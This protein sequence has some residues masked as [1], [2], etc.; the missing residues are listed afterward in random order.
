MVDAVEGIALDQA[1]LEAIYDEHSAIR[2]VGRPLGPGEIGC[3][4]SHRSVY[5]MIVERGIAL[6][7]VLEE[8]AILGPQFK[9]LWQ[10]ASALPADVDLLLLYSEHGFVRRQPSATL[11]GCGLHQAT[12]MLSHA[13]GY[14]VR[15]TCAEALLRRTE[16]IDMVADWPLDHH[17]MRQFL[18]IPMPVSH[19][20]AR[21][22]IIADRPNKNLLGRFHA[23]PWFSAL[24]YLSYIGYLL[25]PGR[26]DNLANYY[27]REV[28][29]RLKRLFSTAE[30]DVG[31]LRAPQNTN[32][33]I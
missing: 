16:R 21:S 24:I 31:T 3:A 27:R 22:T 8:D 30:I 25:Q 33:P 13:V 2:R 12:V 23:P 5:R 14:L 9:S 4:L 28:A 1:T 17:E 18:A 29:R 15:Q 7:L 32:E 20:Y 26:Y 6:A 10:A 11:A 19:D